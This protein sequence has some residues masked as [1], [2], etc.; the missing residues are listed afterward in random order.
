MKT[1]SS[2]VVLQ[3]RNEK[4]DHMP[5]STRPKDIEPKSERRPT[6]KL[7]RLGKPT[8]TLPIRGRR[9]NSN[10]SIW[11]LAICIAIALILRTT[12]DAESQENSREAIE[13]FSDAE[14]QANS[15][16]GALARF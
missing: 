16:K 7:L 4:K 3:P 1:G 13:L 5:P 14:V 2:T 9:R 12:T 8:L 10:V 6:S 15:A 11:V